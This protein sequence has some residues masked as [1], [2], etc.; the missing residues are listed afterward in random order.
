[1]DPEV[2]VDEKLNMNCVL[3]AQKANCILSCI[4]S[5]MTSRV[6]EVT[7][8]LFSSL[9][10]PHLEYCFQLWGPQHKKDVQLFED[11]S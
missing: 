8:F 2:L 11:E 9:M 6:R 1:M 7:A 3:A 5:S 10:R 4:K